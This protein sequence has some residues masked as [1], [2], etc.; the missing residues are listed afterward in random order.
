[1]AFSDADLQV[2]H[3][4][5]ALDSFCLN[6]QSGL[7]VPSW[8]LTVTLLSAKLSTLGLVTFYKILPQPFLTLY[9]LAKGN[10]VQD[11]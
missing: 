8:N 5:L 9:L 4:S 6:T 11:L 10:L 3:Q 1:M 7:Y 2:R